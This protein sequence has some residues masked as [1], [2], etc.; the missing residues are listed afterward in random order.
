MKRLTLPLLILPF[1]SAALA[2]AEPQVL[3]SPTGRVVVTFALSDDGAPAYSVTYAGKP[4]VADSRLGLTLRPIGPLAAGFRVLD[5]KRASRDE[6]Y[7]LVAG[8]TREGHDR[9]EEMTVALEKGGERPVRLDVVFR[10]FD[11]GAAFRYVLPVQPGLP[12]VEIVSEDTRFRFLADHKAWVLELASFTTSN[13]REF[14]PMPLLGIKP[15]SIVGP[16]LTI[17]AGDGLVVSLAEANLRKWSGL[18][19]ARVEGG[20]DSR[21][22]T[23]VT[24]LAPLPSNPGVVVRGARR[25]PRPGACSCSGRSPATSSNRRFSRTSPTPTRSATRPGSSPAKWRG[26]GGTGRWCRTCRGRLA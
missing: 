3:K 21:H 17:E 6:R 2:A 4:V 8:K 20:N 25:W 9:C 10:A 16:P 15:E 1:V 24:K 18:H 7:P 13:E 14:V 22:P 23:L 19:F 26:T 11:D 12:H 5:V